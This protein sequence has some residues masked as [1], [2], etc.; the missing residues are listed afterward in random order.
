VRVTFV[1]PGKPFAK[2]RARA[3]KTGRV[4]TPAATVSFERTVGQIALPHF[5]APLEGPVKLEIIATFAPPPSWSK[6]KASE[7]LHRAHVQRPDLDN[8]LKA[9]SDGLNRIAFADDGQIAEIAARKVWGLTEQT[10]VHV[11]TVG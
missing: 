8:L 6:R 1:I 11:E 5:P 10:V 9:V 7:H 4:F 2:Q 3:T